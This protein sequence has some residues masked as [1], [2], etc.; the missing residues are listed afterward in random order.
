MILKKVNLCSEKKE[1]IITSIIANVK[2][3]L[4]YVTYSSN[5][6]IVYSLRTLSSLAKLKGMIT[7]CSVIRP[8]FIPNFNIILIYSKIGGVYFFPSVPR[9]TSK[10]NT[11]FG[12]KIELFGS[13]IQPILHIIHIPKTNNILFIDSIGTASVFSVKLK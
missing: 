12:N 9:I 4:C 2:D 11:V 10:I 3:S 7:N 6:I 5:I 1:A 13:K 8:I